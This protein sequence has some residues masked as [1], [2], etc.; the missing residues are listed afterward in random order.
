MVRVY[1][2]LGSN[3]GDR[4]A[5]L[6]TAVDRL[7][8]SNDIRFVAA[9]SLYE[10]EPWE[11]PPGRT[12]AAEGWYLNCAVE[13][14]TS[15]PPDRLLDRLQ[16]IEAEL[17]RTRGEGT[18]EAQRFTPRPL[19]IDILLYAD[20]VVSV[21]DRLHVPHLLLHERAFVLRPLAEL[22]PQVEHPVLYRTVHELL[23]EIEDDHGVVP[24]PYPAR[25]FED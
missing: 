24:G 19:D 7:R 10:T 17:G 23:G 15:L 8:A 6:R 11:R 20:R 13:I 3:L 18:P 22:A 25:W 5:A 1:L 9:S 4:L 2:G 16:H 12:H 14:E 21:P